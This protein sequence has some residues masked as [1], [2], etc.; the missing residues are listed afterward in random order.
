MHSLGI[1]RRAP[2]VVLSPKTF[3]E[4]P[5]GFMS[6]VVVLVIA[7]AV[8]IVANNPALH[9]FVVMMGV[10]KIVVPGGRVKL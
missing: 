3:D 2:S 8:V 6:A 5:A 10:V 1:S 4:L 7:V 9:N